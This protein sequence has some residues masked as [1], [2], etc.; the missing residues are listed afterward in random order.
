MVFSPRE[1]HT[2]EEHKIEFL[3][4]DAQTVSRETGEVS[5]TTRLT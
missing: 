2:R 5:Q 3:I 4:A 1:D